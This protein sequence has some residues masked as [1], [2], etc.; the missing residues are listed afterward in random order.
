[1]K[2]IVKK[3]LNKVIKKGFKISIVES[4]TGGLLCKVIT[5]F[6]GSS[7]AFDF[8]LVTYSNKS[9]INILKISKK[10]IK[11]YGS[12]SKQI[13]LSMVRNLYKINKSDI[14]LSITGI[15]GPSGGKKNKPVGLVYIGIKNGDKIIINKYIFKNKGRHYI[16]K[17]AVNKSLKL[18]LATLK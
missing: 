6:P 14:S 13:C 4:C 8:G 1:M 17:A 11:K 9:K 12:V 7:K 16:Q 3:I 5:S 2:F 15:A 18:I 10:T